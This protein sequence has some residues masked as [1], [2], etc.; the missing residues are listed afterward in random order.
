M[1]KIF[2]SFILALAIFG[3]SLNALAFT[4]INLKVTSKTTLDPEIA[5]AYHKNWCEKIQNKMSEKDNLFQEKKGSHLEAYNNL[6]DR[7]ST[8]ISRLESKGHDTAQLEQDIEKL[9]D[10]INK[11]SD[12]YDVYKDRASEAKGYVCD[13]TKAEF[14][15]KLAEVKT[16]L[17]TLK[18]DA[19]DIKNFYL[20]VIKPDIKILK[21]QKISDNQQ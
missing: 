14:K 21:N 3:I 17:K 11:F 5:K 12:D 6:Q 7:L 13:K 8:L 18:A 16:A 4:P 2:L 19:Q 9:N 20:T 1:K 10:K 15:S